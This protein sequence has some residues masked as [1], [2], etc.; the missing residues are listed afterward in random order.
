M[1]ESDSAG[2]TKC[3]VVQGRRAS[4]GTRPG[5]HR[6]QVSGASNWSRSVLEPSATIHPDYG[7]IVA[8]TTDGKVHTGVLRK[9]TDEEL[10][11]LDAEGKL[12]RLPLAEIDQEKR[13]GTSLMPAG[14]HKTLTTE[15]FADLIAYL[16]SLKQ[17]E[18]ESRFGGHAERDSVGRKTHPAGAFAQRGDAVRPSGLDDRR[19]RQQGA[20][21]SSSNRRRGRSG[22]SRRANPS[23]RRS[24]SPTSVK[25]ATTGE[26]EGVV[27]VAFHPRFLE[28]RKYYVN[29]HVRNQ[30]SFFSPVIVERQ[31][32]PDLRRDAGVPSRRLLQI[33]QDTDLHW[34]GMLAFGPDGF[35]YIGAGDAGPQ[36]DPDGHGQDLSRLTGSILRIDVDRQQGGKPYAIPESNPY[37]NCGPSGPSGNLGIG[38]SHAVALQLRPES[39][40]TCGSAT[41]AR[42]CSRRSRSPAPAKTTAGMSTK[43]S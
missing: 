39:R 43:A 31:A 24:C 33:H 7:T 40:A 41:S 38:F 8:T 4:R 42:I 2:C 3:H 13:T 34:G 27:C 17:P 26:F 32:T 18:G 14:Q 21:F 6:R 10:Q 36:E 20:R 15:Q 30:G 37:R 1:F 29:Y 19:A 25:E 5:G 16:E 22:A 12:L 11:L 9:R 23:T 35:L 28:N